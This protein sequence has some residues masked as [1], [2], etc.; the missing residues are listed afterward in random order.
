MTQH[1]QQV[2]HQRRV[3][4]LDPGSRRTGVALSD[5]LGMFAHARPAIHGGGMAAM[6]DDVVRLVGAD[7]V[8]EVVVGLPLSLSGSD[9]GQTASVREFVR[10]L[11]ERLTVPVSTWDERLSSVEAARTARGPVKRKSGELD[12]QS[13]A[14]VL[15]AVLDS[16][17]GGRN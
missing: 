17:R 10:A 7:D 9:S 8:G 11:R 12:S 1:Q 2:P 16:R 13:A 15:Q 4:A 3:L 14:I 5:E 6:V